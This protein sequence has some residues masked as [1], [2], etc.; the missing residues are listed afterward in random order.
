MSAPHEPGGPRDS[1]IRAQFAPDLRRSDAKPSTFVPALLEFAELEMEDGDFD[2]AMAI[3]S[4]ARLLR[5][6]AQLL[7][8]INFL[9]AQGQYRAKRFDVAA[10]AFEQIGHSSS[11]HR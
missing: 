8:R 1:L 7:D 9:A 6:E 5:P 2:G 4:D 3:L 11:R 10:K